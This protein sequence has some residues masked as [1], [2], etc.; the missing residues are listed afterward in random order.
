VREHELE[1]QALLA[2]SPADPRERRGLLR[3]VP[4]ADLERALLLLV[5]ELEPR[6][7]GQ[8]R[9]KLLRLPTEVD[10]APPGAVLGRPRSVVD[11]GAHGGDQHVGPRD[12]ELLEQ[13][14]GAPRRAAG[15]D[16]EAHPVP[17]LAQLPGEALE[18]LVV[19]DQGVVH[20]GDD[21]PVD[22]RD[23]GR[24][25]RHD[26]QVPVRL[27]QDLAQPLQV[28]RHVAVP[29]VQ[30]VGAPDPAP[31]ASPPQ[32]RVVD[33]LPDRLRDRG[34][35]EGIDEEAVLATLHDVDGAAVPRRHDRQAARRG[36]DERQPERL[37][38]RGI[39][40]HPAEPSRVSVEVRDV[41]GLVALGIGDRAVEIVLVDEEEELQQDPPRA[42]RLVRD[43][44]PRPGQDHEVRPGP[45]SPAPRVGA[46]QRRQVLPN[47]GARDREDHRTLRKAE[48]AIDLGRDRRAL[49]T[50][51][52]RPESREVHARRE[53]LHSL[54]GVVV[55]QLVLLADL[56]AG[57]RDDQRRVLEGP[58][59]GLDPLAEVVAAFDHLGVGVRVEEPLSLDASERVPREH[60]RHP[61]ELRDL[62]PHVAGVRVVRV[63]H[64]RKHAVRADVVHRVVDEPVEVRPEALL[65][66]IAPRS[67]GDADDPR[68]VAEG[69]LG[70]RVDVV[71]LLRLDLPRHEDDVADARLRGER[72]RLV[73]HVEDLP[74]RIGV[75]TQLDVAAPDEPVDT[76]GE[77]AQRRL[78]HRDP[79]SPGG[80]PRR[81]TGFRTSPRVARR[82]SPR[83]GR[84]ARSS[85]R[86]ASPAEG[87]GSPPR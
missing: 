83:S 21:H 70:L 85:R 2:Q 29:G 30:P 75:A 13:R 55:V 64:V 86:G 26:P 35:V 53:D 47:V 61:E 57:A 25:T 63:N 67:A 41:P 16:R 42:A 82:R 36:L 43:A 20:V 32:V 62:R 4:V 18:G 8:D 68:A 77:D 46:H 87:R 74:A 81:A 80:P 22:S 66:Q 69:L 23:R 39:D 6:H 7:L 15:G 60:E 34:R 14:D 40:E 50:L 27:S 11:L 38:Q 33:Q 19:A 31:G 24:T 1:P 10:V 78:S 17:G 73:H 56:L 76:Q 37:G 12:V 5:L 84:R 9:A 49:L 51:L 59:L 79:R 44:L 28:A 58:F 54:R 72:L 3:V 65:A 71:V 52:R 48:E 45:E